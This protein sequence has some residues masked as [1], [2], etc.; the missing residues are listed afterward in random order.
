[1]HPVSAYQCNIVEGMSVED[2][3]RGWGRRLDVGFDVR[4][5]GNAIHRCASKLCH[6]DL[7]GNI[8]HNE[9][10]ASRS[11]PP[12]YGVAVP[13]ASNHFSAVAQMIVYQKTLYNFKK[14]ARDALGYPVTPYFCPRGLPAPS[15]STLAMT[16]LSLAC[17]YASASCSYV[18]A[19]FY[20]C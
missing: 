2:E 18:G 1:M 5:G 19:R 9:V 7:H 6:T 13:S 11:R 3:R 10:R 17:E 4:L 12:S 8:T 20:K 16:T 15:A 14:A